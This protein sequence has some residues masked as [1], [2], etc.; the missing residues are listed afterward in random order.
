VEIND[1]EGNTCLHIA[2]ARDKLEYVKVLAEYIPVNSENLK[3]QTPL[4][5][6]A[7]EGSIDIVEYLLKFGANQ[8]LEP[9]DGD[10]IRLLADEVNELKNRHP[11]KNYDEEMS[12]IRSKISKLRIIDK[13]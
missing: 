2:S 10:T 5:F 1:I 3:K 13:L 7:Y 9:V 6:A 4:H 12:Y 8:K 11:N